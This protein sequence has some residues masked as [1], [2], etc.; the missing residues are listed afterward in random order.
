MG[1]GEKGILLLP[2]LLGKEYIFKALKFSLKL[3]KTSKF[4]QG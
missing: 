1:S 2:D 3:V 4:V